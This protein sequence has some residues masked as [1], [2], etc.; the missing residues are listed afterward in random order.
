MY[1]SQKRKFMIANSQMVT[2]CKTRQ[3]H[4]SCW[5]HYK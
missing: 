2:F 5:A 1:I 3:N 4:D